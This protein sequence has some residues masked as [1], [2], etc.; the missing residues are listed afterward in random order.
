M[1]TVLH[2]LPHRG[3]GAETYLDLLE[4]LAGFT[5]ERVALSAGRTPTAA[6]RSLPLRYAAIARAARRADLVHVHGDAATLLALPLLRG[7]PA[8]WTTHGLHL[9]RRRPLI[10][11]GVRAAIAATA[12]T[13]CTSR[14][15]HD[16]LAAIAPR[17]HDRLAVARNGLP[18]APPPDAAARAAARAQLGLADGEVAALFLGELEE[19]K[20][21]LDAAFAARRARGEGAPLTLLVAGRGPL[22]DQV[23]AAGEEAVRMLGFR[24]DPD[25]LLAA[26]DVFVLPSAREGLS[27]AVLEAMRAG[28][29]CVV[30]DGPGN[31]EAVGDAGVVLPA[32]D[33]DALARA[34]ARLA[35][36][37][38]ERA[39]LG[40]AAR[41][42][43]AGE[44]SAERML[45]AVA[46]AYER[47]L[48]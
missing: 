10:A 5:H 32:G 47:A 45:A 24:D 18:A 35:R 41:A 42:R 40:A 2:V 15:E 37:P 8:V 29:P 7:R 14:A 28:L 6:A 38:D 11:P 43:V 36:D 12:V 25:R 4:E 21:P 23:A 39:R 31:P 34:L 46:A 1:R 16:E 22:S 9:L 30:A 17:H 3:G 13:L 27:F 33:V 48:S 44:L 19:R 20:R 26:A